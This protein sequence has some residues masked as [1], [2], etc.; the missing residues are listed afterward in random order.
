MYKDTG[1]PRSQGFSL[2]EMDRSCS[3]RVSDRSFVI[4]ELVRK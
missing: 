2:G 4:S 1:R 3:T